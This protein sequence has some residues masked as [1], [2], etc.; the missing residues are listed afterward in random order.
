MNPSRRLTSTVI[1]PQTLVSLLAWCCFAWNAPALAA[2]A[3][4]PAETLVLV[5]RPSV[6]DPLYVQAILLA[7]QLPGG[8][9]VGFI[10]NKPTE[11]T[12]TDAFP[13][14]EASKS[15]TEPIYLGGPAVLNTVFAVVH[16]PT[17]PVDG[18]LALTGNLYLAISETA[19]D[20]AMTAAPRERARF[21]LG[22][23]LWQL[24]ELDAQ[25]DQGDWYI[26]KA[27]PE[28]V[29]ST[30]TAGLWADL[31]RQAQLAATWI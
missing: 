2:D 30:H 29:L 18:T 28:L 3:A 19:V 26:L 13:G 31:V 16:S 21:Y 1:S 22:A 27:T 15:V 9:H 25:I 20:D 12:L 7:R 23:V 5:A 24:G 14:Q 4:D 6:S 8:Q 17:T 10:L 11:L